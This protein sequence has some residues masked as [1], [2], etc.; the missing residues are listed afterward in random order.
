M[1]KE[2]EQEEERKLRKKKITMMQNKM[3]RDTMKNEN[4]V[5]E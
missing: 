2:N 4:V 3:G 1:G 5:S